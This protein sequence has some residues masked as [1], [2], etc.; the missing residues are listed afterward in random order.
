MK[1][2]R[3]TNKR[4]GDGQRFDVNQVSKEGI[5]KE[6]IEAA[7]KKNLRLANIFKT[8]DLDKSG[9]LSSQELALAMDTFKTFD[10]DGN[11]KLSNNEFL[12]MAES[13]RNEYGE[14]FLSKDFKDFMNVIR[15]ATKK[16]EKVSTQQLVGEYYDEVNHT[17][18]M[19]SVNNYAKEQGL[20]L[21]EGHEG[22]YYDVENDM[23]Y[24]LYEEGGKLSLVPAKYDEKANTVEYMTQEEYDAKELRLK[25]K[26][27]PKQ[28]R[29]QKQKPRQKPKQKPRLLKKQ[30]PSIPMLYNPVTAL[31]K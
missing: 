9:D 18:K 15:K 29:R 4:I 10:E 26:Q 6:E 19:N 21:V 5:S 24:K 14:N 20:A 27:K 17:I 1:G 23:Y 30:N 16:D 11:S 7:K 12:K 8:F 25:Q 3:M 22:A 13:F 28:K 2:V 31:L